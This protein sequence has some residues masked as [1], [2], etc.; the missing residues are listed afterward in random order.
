MWNQGFFAFPHVIILLLTQLQLDLSNLNFVL[1]SLSQNFLYSLAH[2]IEFKVSSSF[3]TGVLL[4][5]VVVEVDPFV[6]DQISNI[7]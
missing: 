7:G 6:I 3:R 1:L 5:I 2:I 4:S